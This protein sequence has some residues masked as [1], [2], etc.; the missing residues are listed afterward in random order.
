MTEHPTSFERPQGVDPADPR[1]A[2]LRSPVH[3]PGAALETPPYEPGGDGKSNPGKDGNDPE[4]SQPESAE[5]GAH[6]PRPAPEGIPA[7]PGG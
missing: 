1:G 5:Q 4:H 2:L 3:A 6:R 7:Q